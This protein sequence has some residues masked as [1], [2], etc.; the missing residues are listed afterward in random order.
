MFERRRQS[1]RS[2]FGA[3]QTDHEKRTADMF[4]K[5]YKAYA[6]FPNYGDG[7]DMLY[8]GRRWMARRFMKRA[9]KLYDWYDGKVLLELFDEGTNLSD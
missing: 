8:S 9:I 7:Y 2:L 1:K 6:P 4:L 5:L 3:G